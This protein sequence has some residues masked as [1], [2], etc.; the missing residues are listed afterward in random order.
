MSNCTTQ[1]PLEDER[2][3]NRSLEESKK[4]TSK[5]VGHIWAR[6]VYDIEESVYHMVYC[7]KIAPKG[8]DSVRIFRTEAEAQAQRTLRNIDKPKVRPNAKWTI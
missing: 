8:P 5:K 3:F 4:V 1:I 7:L 2:W 6:Q